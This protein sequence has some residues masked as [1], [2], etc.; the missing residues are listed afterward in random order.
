VQVQLVRE[1]DSPW[2]DWISE[3]AVIKPASQGVP[4]LSGY[5]I[6]KKLYIGIAPGNHFLAVAATKG[7]I[8]PTEAPTILLANRNRPVVQPTG[9]LAIGPAYTSSYVILHCLVN[10]LPHWTTGYLVRQQAGL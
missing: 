6:R 8:V 9:P 4:R 3:Y 7:G 1:D 2:S 10:G 5:G